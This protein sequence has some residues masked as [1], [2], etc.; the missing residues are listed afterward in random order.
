MRATVSGATGLIGLHVAGALIARGDEV[1]VLTRD[2]SRASALLPE[3]NAVAWDP[4][5]EEAPPEALSGREA[6]VHLAGEPVAQRWTDKAKDRIRESRVVGTANL[7]AGL[8][9][10][11]ARPSVLVSGS[12]V[13][14]YGPRGDEPVDESAGAGEDFLAKVCVD[15]ELAARQAAE[16]G[17]R[18]VL[19]RT[20][21]VLAA[22][23]GALAKMLG[24]FKAGVGGPVAGGRQYMPWIHLDDIVSLIIAAIDGDERWAGPVN[25]SAPAPATNTEFSKALGR[26]LH[27]PAVAPVPAAA[28]KLL[29]GEMSQIVTTGQNAV[30]AKAGALGFTWQH[31]D[32]EPALADTLHR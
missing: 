28:M 15:W 1:T 12:A 18:T 25:G 23:E 11:E 22:D 31:P 10:A 5:S 32:L 27:R 30:P 20:G 8:R 21:I 6:V 14:F 7:V 4:S 29:Y 13:G 9:Q 16:L 3:A 24:P 26:V 2:P 19:L 17:I